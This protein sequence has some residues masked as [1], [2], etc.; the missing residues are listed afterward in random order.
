MAKRG[1]TPKRAERAAKVVTLH[2]GGATFEVIAK[3][4]GI[5]YTQARNDYERAMEDARP[6]NARHVFAKLTRRLNRLHAA[7]WKR[8]LEGDIKAARLV[9]DINKQLAQL[10]GLEGAVKLDIEVTGG[11]EFASA[12]TSFRASIEAMGATLDDE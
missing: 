8:A 5:S 12:I 3:Q 11:D 10:W 2:D 4:L 9:L 7:Y 6:D 1:M